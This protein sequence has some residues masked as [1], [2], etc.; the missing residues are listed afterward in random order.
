ME[1]RQKVCSLR[2][3]NNII[4]HP[5][6]ENLMEFCDECHEHGI[7]KVCPFCGVEITVDPEVAELME[8]YDIDDNAALLCVDCL[9]AVTFIDSNIDKC[10]MIDNCF[11]LDT[12]INDTHVK[13]LTRERI[14]TDDDNRSDRAV[15]Y[16]PE[17]KIL[18]SLNYN[19]IQK[20]RNT[21][22]LNKYTLFVSYP[23]IN[24][25]E[26]QIRIKPDPNYEYIYNNIGIYMK[27][28]ID[29]L[30][31]LINT[32]IS[33]DDEKEK[34]SFES[35]LSSLGFK[36]VQIDECET[37]IKNSK[38]MVYTNISDIIDSILES[39]SSTKSIDE[40]IKYILK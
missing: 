27:G 3:C 40:I 26:N 9:S 28:C 29:D 37:P 12:L 6:R 39:S 33:E 15:Y 36:V 4:S 25:N 31:K 11:A 16:H 22:F 24:S 7:V 19:M 30:K 21:L 13:N 23:S 2:G 17:L 32:M 1:R 20:I 14:F 5:K 34:K 35:C 8:F 18:F 38:G 10:E